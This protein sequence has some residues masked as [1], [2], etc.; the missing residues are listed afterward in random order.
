MV[1]EYQNVLIYFCPSI[2]LFPELIVDCIVQSLRQSH[3]SQAQTS[4]Y[5]S[6]LLAA[7]ADRR[8]RILKN[9]GLEVTNPLHFAVTEIMAG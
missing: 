4:P 8:G 5:P 1:I 6:R 3:H 2:P 7:F 9:L